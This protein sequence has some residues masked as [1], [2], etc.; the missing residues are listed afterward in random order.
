MNF[1]N[2]MRISRKLFAAFAILVVIAAGVGGVTMVQVKQVEAVSDRS[3][4]VQHMVDLFGQLEQAAFGQLLS[5]R[6]LLLTG[7]RENIAKFDAFGE[8]LTGLYGKLEKV[9]INPQITKGLQE[10]RTIIGDWQQNVAQKQIALMRGPLTVD[11]SRV[12]EANGAG[13]TFANKL[14]ATMGAIQ[15]VA[16]AEVESNAHASA[17]AFRTTIIAVTAGLVVSVLF[18]MAAG[19]FLSRGI[20]RPI[21]LLNG[22][23]LRLAQKDYSGDIPGTGRGD[24][25]GQMANT[26]MVFKNGMIENDRL[27]E[28]AQKKQEAELER[29]RKLQALTQSFDTEVSEMMSTLAA[30][31]TELQGT[32]TSLTTLAEGSSD[33]AVTAS[34]TSQATSANVQTV[35]TAGT[36]LSASIAEISRQVA[37]SNDLARKA[38]DEAEESNT[39]VEALVE[40]AS[41]IGEVITL[42]RDIADQ[43]NLLALNATIE[44][45]RAGE[46]GKGFAVVAQEV[47]SLANET[48]KATEDIENQ[49]ARIQERTDTAVKAIRSI[50]ERI[51]EMESVVSTVAA[52]VE[53]QDAAT[54]EISSK[55]EEVSMAA[56]EMAQSMS[57]VRDAAEQ[58]GESSGDVLTTSEEL[59]K[60]AEKLKASVDNFLTNVRA[61]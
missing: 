61:A 24:E 19:V 2:S 6:G 12:M 53:E 1:L 43:T 29:G 30:A 16:D 7:D 28:E 41:K 35:A 45:A 22:V 14:V 9:T 40:D 60:Q 54:R 59:S 21:E 33:R 11:E 56:D 36:E 44:S 27:Q 46:A 26:V 57:A 55:V 48:S 52:A 37:S 18:A 32:A 58:T 38:R 47:K 20:S 10:L 25:I 31:A 17:V 34:Q 5:V 23:M 42:I 3:A 13:E 15:T 51:V 4:Q 49:V 50:S 8:E 39:A